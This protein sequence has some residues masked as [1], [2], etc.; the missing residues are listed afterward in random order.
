MTSIS[1]TSARRRTS[2]SRAAQLSATNVYSPSNEL[3]RMLVSPV[4][5]TFEQAEPGG[6]YWTNRG[7]SVT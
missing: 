5:I 4:P 3:G 1:L 6:V 7:S 2:S